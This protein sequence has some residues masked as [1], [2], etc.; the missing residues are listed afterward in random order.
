MRRSV[1]LVLLAGLALALFG[2]LVRDERSASRRSEPTEYRPTQRE[3]PALVASGPWAEAPAPGFSRAVLS[4]SRGELAKEL[5]RVHGKVLVE[6]GGAV[7]ETVALQV[8]L[9]TGL[10]GKPAD[11]LVPVSADG[12]FEFPVSARTTHVTLELRARGLFTPVEVRAVPGEE[13]TVMAKRRAQVTSPSRGWSITGRVLDEDGMPFVGARVFAEPAC[14]PGGRGYAGG[15]ATESVKSES[16][17]GEDGRFE[18]TGLQLVHVRV[19]A[20]SP[21]AVGGVDLDVDA[22]SGDVHD[23]VLT[24]ARGGCIH[25]LVRWPDGTP[26]RDFR[27]EA[28]SNSSGRSA[29]F[30]SGTFEVCGLAP[31][32]EWSVHVSAQDGSR[33]GAGEARQLRT[34]GP[35]IDIVLVEH[36]PPFAL[37]VRVHDEQGAPVEGFH[38]WANTSDGR[39]RNM[40]AGSSA[41]GRVVIHGLTAGPWTL[42][43]T[44]PGFE[45]SLLSVELAPGSPPLSI[46]LER[47]GFIRGIVRGTDGKLV[48]GA[49]VEASRKLE[50]GSTR[51]HWRMSD[52]ISDAQGHFELEVPSG[53]GQLLAYDAG[54]ATSAALDYEIG[55]GQTLEGFVLTLE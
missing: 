17:S 9:Y 38:V 54:G 25:G 26:V 35:P 27:C 45:S 37:E 29:S 14:D 50:D 31:A 4:E 36:G 1:V 5:P 53:R 19:R 40:G 21:E 44:A 7:G 39:G 28:R 41:E 6:G 47:S 33:S 42:T 55:P 18:L 24:L 13:T 34:G 3:R 10:F 8:D 52:A 43:V 15:D 30:S 16:H 48:V 46:I 2:L 32:E 12:A 51:V 11:E 23:L 20:T 49:F 22:E